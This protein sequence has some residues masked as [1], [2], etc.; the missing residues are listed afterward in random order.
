MVRQSELRGYLIGSVALGLM[1]LLLARVFSAYALVLV[2]SANSPWLALAELVAEIFH[3]AHEANLDIL[4]MAIDFVPLVALP[5]LA[6]AGTDSGGRDH[7]LS[8]FGLL[9]VGLSAIGLAAAGLGTVLIDP[10]TSR[11]AAGVTVANATAFLTHLDS[12]CEQACRAF[13]AFLAGLTG[14]LPYR[15][16]EAAE[17]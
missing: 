16:A 6:F 17:A 3:A 14:L 10:D 4:V 8:P 15:R 7:V 11:L 12:S 1:L 9:L 13:V 2:D 5:G